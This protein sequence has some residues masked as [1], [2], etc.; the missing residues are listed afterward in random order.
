MI[1]EL[2]CAGKPSLFMWQLSTNILLVNI[3]KG[4]LIVLKYTY[5]YL[6]VYISKNSL[7]WWPV[8]K[9]SYLYVISLSNSMVLDKSSCLSA[10]CCRLSRVVVGETGILRLDRTAFLT[11]FLTVYSWGQPQEAVFDMFLIS[12]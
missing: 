10:F 3:S 6:Y 9:I 11:C 1:E 7:L 5:V 4:T 8:F 2:T 12:P